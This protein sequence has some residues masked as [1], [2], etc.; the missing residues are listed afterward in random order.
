MAK[1]FFLLVAGRRKKELAC[2]EKISHSL[3]LQQ[4]GP[5]T[6]LVQKQFFCKQI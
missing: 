1:D 5:A 6:L 3:L 4:N 2:N